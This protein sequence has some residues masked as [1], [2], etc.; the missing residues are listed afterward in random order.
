MKRARYRRLWRAEDGVGAIEFA[1]VAGILSILLLG[2]CDF[3]LGFWEKM[4]VANAARAG[5][6]FAVR[7]GYNST[8]IQ[9]A[10]T[11]A[12]NLSGVQANPAPAQTCGCPDAATGVSTATCGATCPNGTTAGSYV[13]VNAQVSYSTI[14]AWPGISSPLTLASSVTVRLD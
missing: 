10:V 5:A 6:E 13:T 1:F 8:N 7:N 4:Q 12:T 3:G 2:I 11:N 14:F 9:T